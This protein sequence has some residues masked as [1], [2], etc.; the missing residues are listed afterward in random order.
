MID[1]YNAF[2][3]RDETAQRSDQAGDGPLAGI[4]VGV[5]ANIAVEGMPFHA[6]IGVWED[7]RA[8]KDAA[9][10]QRLRDAGAAIVGILNME[11]GALG[12]KTDNPHFGPTENPHR[13]GYSP[14]GSSGGSG[15]AVAAGLCDVALGT[16]TM[17]SVRIP[18]SHCGVYGFKPATDRVSQ[19]GL[20]PADPSLDA[21]GPL[22]RDLD[23]LERA[24][25]VM[26]H[27]GEAA[28]DAGGATLVEHGVDIALPVA[29]AFQAVTSLL[30]QVPAQVKLSES[31]SRIRFAGFVHVSRFMA[32]DL[33]GLS[34]SA[35]LARLLSYGPERSE[36]K[37]ALDR[38]VLNQ[39]RREVLEIIERH[40]F[41]IM[42][43][44][45]NPPFPH[46]EAEP[47]AQADFTCLA[48]IAGLPAISLPMGYTPDGLPMGVQLVGASGAEAGLF[49]LARQFDAKLRAYRKPQI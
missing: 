33:A 8:D 21:I 6:G 18:A 9:V 30:D 32:D 28:I 36:G 4:S 44:V 46:S 23:T 34:V 22:A 38:D 43:S 29:T 47:A 5:K 40:G 20:I 16:D 3:Y 27:F 39:A 10:V 2:L 26:S 24:A 25:R 37:L 35:R 49:R 1:R 41:L 12:S 42:P 19:D 13:Q 48:N 45:P 15:A 31:N 7:R 17:G 11:E 14:G